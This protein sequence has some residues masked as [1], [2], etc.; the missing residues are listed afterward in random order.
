[1]S[2]LCVSIA[3]RHVDDPSVFRGWR[4]VAHD[5][6]ANGRRAGSA[7]CSRRVPRTPGGRVDG[8]VG[9]PRLQFAEEVQ[10]HVRAAFRWV[11]GPAGFMREDVSWL[12]HTRA[13]PRE[14]DSTDGAL[15]FQACLT[16]NRPELITCPKP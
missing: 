6:R 4:G 15:P 16:P 1:M 13:D 12:I 3:Q 14:W 7:R 9:H 5:F 2:L 10:D 11:M 8:S